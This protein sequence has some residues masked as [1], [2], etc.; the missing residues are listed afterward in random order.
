MTLAVSADEDGC[1][2]MMSGCDGWVDVLW[3]WREKQKFMFRHRPLLMKKD[4][5]Y[6][7]YYTLS[8]TKFFM[9]IQRKE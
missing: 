7:Y 4:S 1:C 9:N 3:M 6:A 2:T 8:K 5:A